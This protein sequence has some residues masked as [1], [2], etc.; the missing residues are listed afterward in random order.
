MSYDMFLPLVSIMVHA[1][2]FASPENEWRDLF[3]SY[4]PDWLTINNSEAVRAFYLG[5]ASIFETRY[6]LPWVKPAFWWCIFTFVLL[7]RHAMHQCY[8]SQTLG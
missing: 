5:D 4:L 1:F 2:Y 8:H 3:W 7:F 6:F